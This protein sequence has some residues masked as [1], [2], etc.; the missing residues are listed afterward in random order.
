[1]PTPR[2]TP[3]AW[4]KK[5][6]RYPPSS[7]VPGPRDPALTPYM[8]PWARAIA[9]GGGRF[10][11]AVMVA[12]AQS[13]KTDA[14]LDVIGSRLHTRPAPIMYVG[15]SR[16]FNTDQFEPRLMALFDQAPSLADKLARGQRNKKT[17]KLVAGVPIR[18]AHAG[19]S[20]SLKSDPAAIA[21]VDEYDEMLR[22]V[23]GQGDP[24]GLVEARG[25]S[26]A[27]FVVGVA[28]TPSLGVGDVEKD[29]DFRPRVLEAGAARGSAKSDLAAVA[30][31]HAAPSGVALSALSR[32][33]HPALCASEVA[34][35]RRRRA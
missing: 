29:P 1:M 12:A 17:K 14:L 19:S 27:D 28:S 16:D 33:F 13:G 25:F 22:N 26:F 24:L 11:R 8:I 20:T 2:T 7:G 15:P 35:S 21:L 32:I 10:R 23:K 5:N 30:G 31:G 34:A 9:A 4:A 18:L 3:D 6:R